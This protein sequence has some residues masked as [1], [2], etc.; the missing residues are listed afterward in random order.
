MFF[1]FFYLDWAILSSTGGK[2]SKPLVQI[3]LNLVHFNQYFVVAYQDY[4]IIFAHFLYV[5]N[6][7]LLLSSIPPYSECILKYIEL[8]VL[9]AP[10]SS[11]LEFL[12]TSTKF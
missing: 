2:Q 6:S 9:F 5:C 11:E 7:F 8:E 12:G 10:L 4:I 3:C 1:L